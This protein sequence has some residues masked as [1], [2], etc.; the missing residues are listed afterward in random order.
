MSRIGQTPI[1]LPA[2]VQISREDLPMT[3]ST[4][5]STVSSAPL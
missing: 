5:L 3:D 4:A 2:G 1:P